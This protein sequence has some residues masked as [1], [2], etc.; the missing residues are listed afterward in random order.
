M[1]LFVNFNEYV[2][3]EESEEMWG[4]W[5]K[6]HSYEFLTLTSKPAGLDY[7]SLT[8][9]IEPSIG[10]TY[11]FVYVLYNTGDSFGNASGKL[12]E[13]GVY[14]SVEKANHISALIQQNANS[15]SYKVFKDMDGLPVSTSRWKGYFED[16][17]S[18]N[19]VPLVWEG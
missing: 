9:S 1:Q 7:E 13:I 17:S 8:A 2:E 11:Y 15:D 14:D 12:A 19:T 3:S 16:F 10:E 6:D 4:S 18:V 5:S